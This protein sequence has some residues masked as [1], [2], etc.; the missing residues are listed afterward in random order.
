[1]ELQP[2]KILDSEKTSVK[3]ILAFHFEELLKSLKRRI[4]SK[5]SIRN[6][7]KILISLPI[8]QSVYYAWFRAVRDSQPSFGRILTTNKNKRKNIVEERIEFKHRGVFKY[9]IG[10]TLSSNINIESFMKKKL[11]GLSKGSLEISEENPLVF[12][13]SRT[14][15]K[16]V[17]SGKFRVVNRYGNPCL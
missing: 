12:S 1:M 16:L 11:P 2:Y 10:Q 5:V 13:Y 17:V 3:P 7:R 15:G 4:T 9:H 8:H 14:R 6:P